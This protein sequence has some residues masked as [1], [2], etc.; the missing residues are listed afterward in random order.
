MK[1]TDAQIATAAARASWTIG[2][3]SF[4][5][6]VDLPFE[7]SPGALIG[8]SGRNVRA[9]EE[10]TGCDLLLDEAPGKA[11]VSAFDPLRR[12]LG[13]L[14][15]LNLLVEGRI[16][17]AR[18]AEVAREAS[19]TLGKVAR[20]LAEDA[21]SQASIE[22][23]PE[24]ALEDLGRLAWLRAG[25]TSEISLA[26]SASRLARSIAV[27]TGDDPDAHAVAGLLCRI[28]LVAPG[29]SNVAEESARRAAAY[30]LPAET[31]R[32]VSSEAVE[33]ARA[34]AESRLGAIRPALESAWQSAL[35]LESAAKSLP[36]VADA[37][38][39]KN[40]KRMVVWLQEGADAEPVQALCRSGSI[41]VV[42]VRAPG[43]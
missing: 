16:H 2:P 14:T 35:S 29:H 42:A 5:L 13:R 10:A 30:G 32:A 38:V 12:Q 43:A 19:R 8:R 15:L 28:G 9:F 1:P 17:S 20:I 31:V 21:V 6:A 37:V 40:G 36:G 23:L 34:L 27:E 3:P 24:A 4:S 25:P 11:V 7:E 39:M 41:E 18:V 33:A 26:V 22:P